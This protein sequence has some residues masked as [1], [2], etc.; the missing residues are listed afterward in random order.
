MI[1]KVTIE[2]ITKVSLLK[3]EELADG[4]SFIFENRIYIV[5]KYEN[6]YAF[7]ICGKYVISKGD[8]SYYH[9]AKLVNLRV[10]VE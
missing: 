8:M 6:I 1:G 4:T 10:I 5:N 2:N 3:I 9:S 7:S